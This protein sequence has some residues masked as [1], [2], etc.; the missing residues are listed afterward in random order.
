MSLSHND[1]L[2]YTQEAAENFGV[3]PARKTT[4]NTAAA[5]AALGQSKDE[6]RRS[7]RGGNNQPEGER[8]E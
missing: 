4:F 8:E 7:R 1:A 3:G 2:K 5:K 6:R